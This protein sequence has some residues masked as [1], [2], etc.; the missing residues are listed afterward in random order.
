MGQKRNNSLAAQ[1]NLT[2]SMSM[3]FIEYIAKNVAYIKD[4]QLGEPKAFEIPSLEDWRKLRY[5]YKVNM[6]RNL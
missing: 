4:I 3:A 1:H 6:E 5:E 2:Q